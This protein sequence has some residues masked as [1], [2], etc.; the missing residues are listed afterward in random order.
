MYNS[1]EICNALDINIEE[2]WNI[3][4]YGSRIYGTNNEHSDYDYIIVYKASLL[5]NGSFKNNAISSEDRKI[6]GICYSR[7]GFI[8]AINNYDISALECIS[9]DDDMLLKKKFDF[10]INRYYE[11]EMVKKIISKASN[12]FHIANEAYCYENYDQA[13]KG[14]Y[15]ALRILEFGQQIKQSQKITDFSV[16]INLYEKVMSDE[17]FSVKKYI[18]NRD[19]LIAKLRS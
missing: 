14:V 10:K 13:H 5:P 7:G 17:D 19:E 16:A 8:D 12:S 2:I 1:E 3:Y 18:P 6:Q 11:K 4:P 15:H 9:L